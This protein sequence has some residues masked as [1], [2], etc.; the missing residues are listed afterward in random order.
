M[1]NACLVSGEMKDNSKLVTE[2]I[3]KELDIS[4]VQKVTSS[5]PFELKKISHYLR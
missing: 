5:F 1:K 4:S 3:H 2:T